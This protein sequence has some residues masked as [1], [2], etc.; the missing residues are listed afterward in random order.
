[1]TGISAVQRTQ[2][3]KDI[4]HEAEAVLKVP[5]AQVLDRLK[6]LIERERKLAKEVEILKQ[7]TAASGGQ[8]DP[9]Q[10]ARVIAGVKVLFTKTKGI[11]L[12]S[13][14]AFVDQLRDKLGGGVVLASAEENGK[15]S[16]VCSVS[17]ELTDRVRAGDVLKALFNITGGRGGG[18]ADF[19][20]GGGGDPALLDKA[21]EAFYQL[22]GTTLD[23]G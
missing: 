8:A 22:I 21:S 14:R 3:L 12:A 18:R 13:L 15:L 2:K 23:N 10:A 16:L 11:E 4:V 7:Q 20:Q 17:K 6:A 1:V 9:T 19:A 5:E